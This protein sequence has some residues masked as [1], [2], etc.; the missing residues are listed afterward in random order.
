MC[1]WLWEVLSHISLNFVFFTFFRWVYTSY[2]GGVSML[3]K[4]HFEQINGMS[5]LY[6]GWGGEDDDLYAR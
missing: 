1:V 6:W 2:M 4:E 3:R 5:N